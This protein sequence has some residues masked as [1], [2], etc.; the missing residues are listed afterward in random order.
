MTSFV[1]LPARHNFISEGGSYTKDLP[2]YRKFT[3]IGRSPH[4]IIM[5]AM[6]GQKNCIN[7]A[8]YQKNTIFFPQKR[9]NAKCPPS[10]VQLRR[11][12]QGQTPYI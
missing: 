9:R 11:I 12:Q 1:I 4:L 8:L 6:T 2:T 7:L 10:L 3:I 5:P